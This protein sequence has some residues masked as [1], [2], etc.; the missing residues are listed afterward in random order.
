MPAETGPFGQHRGRLQYGRQQLFGRR[1]R[2]FLVKKPPDSLVQIGLRL[3]RK[4]PH[5]R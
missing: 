3:G 2:I 4:I 1:R 5:S